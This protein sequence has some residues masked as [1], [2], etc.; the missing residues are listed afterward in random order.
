MTDDIH[1]ELEKLIPDHPDLIDELELSDPLQSIGEVSSAS[2]GDQTEV[3]AAGW[4]AEGRDVR[5]FDQFDRAMAMRTTH[6]E[7]ARRG[8]AQ[9]IE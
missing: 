1:S 4:A 2:V 7:H 9:R 5:V 6:I 8:A 3:A